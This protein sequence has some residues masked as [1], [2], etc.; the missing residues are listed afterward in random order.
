MLQ[1]AENGGRHLMA[2]IPGRCTAQKCL[3]RMLA[4]DGTGIWL[5][6][7][8]ARGN[9]LRSVVCAVSASGTVNA[10]RGGRGKK[11]FQGRE[12]IMA[13]RAPVQDVSCYIQP[14]HHATAAAVAHAPHPEFRGGGRN[15]R[16]SAMQAVADCFETVPYPYLTHRPMLKREGA[17]G[18][19]DV[20]YEKSTRIHDHENTLITMARDKSHGTTAGDLASVSC[21]FSGHADD[22]SVKSDA[23][24]R[25]D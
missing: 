9:R 23:G 25:L 17:I 24:I 3:V 13:A 21:I 12:K 14:L 16:L 19:Q 1:S 20:Y 5:T 10:M 18:A 4:C 15:M 6:G 2:C 8:A 7:V 11:N 22:A